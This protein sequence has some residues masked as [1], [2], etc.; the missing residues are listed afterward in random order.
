[1]AIRV[2][3]LEG[4]SL[5]TGIEVHG[6]ILYLSPE[7]GQELHILLGQDCKDPNCPC[8]GRGRAEMKGDS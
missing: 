4:G 1:M 2:W 5:F 7:E 8:C 6:I 3:R